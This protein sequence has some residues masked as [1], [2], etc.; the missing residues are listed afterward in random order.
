MSS[1][2]A[3]PA[4]EARSEAQLSEVRVAELRSAGPR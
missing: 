2:S 3:K 1:M 4:S